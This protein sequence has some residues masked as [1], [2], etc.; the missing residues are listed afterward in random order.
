MD[1]GSFSDDYLSDLC[2]SI[3]EVR[4][5]LLITGAGISADSGLP[6]Y[7]GV[8]GLYEDRNTVDGIPIEVALS[9]GMFSRQPRVTWKYLLEIA[10]ACSG[11]TWNRGHQVM[12]DLE[13]FIPEVWILTQNIDG[14]HLDAGSSNVIEIHGSMRRLRCTECSFQISTSDYQLPFGFD[15]N[16][17]L[18]DCPDCS[19][20]IRPDVTLF[21]EMLPVPAVEELQDQ[22]AIG[23]D[24]IIIV[25]T[26]AVFPY[27]AQPVYQAA[28]QGQV[29]VEINP[30]ETQLS[31][32]V[33]WKIE[34]SATEGLEQIASCFH[35]DSK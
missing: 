20:M 8:S 21:D 13:N 9:G 6:T 16:A 32:V 27:I 19:S 23:F 15:E 26:S 34:K 10:N 35:R 18:P 2:V 22:L 24:G 3:R 7:R 5:M 31:S 29:T 28:Q 11:K 33:Q 25:G 1:E 4:R 17:R 12:V 30:A 14:F